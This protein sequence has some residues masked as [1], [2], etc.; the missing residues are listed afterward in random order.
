MGIA[1]F[2]NRKIK[3]DSEST[4]STTK[5]PDHLLKRAKQAKLKIILANHNIET[6]EILEC[7]DCDEIAIHEAN[8][9][10]NPL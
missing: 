9:E 5:I 1:N 4:E 6:C 8:L 3:S 2:F 10:I 7:N